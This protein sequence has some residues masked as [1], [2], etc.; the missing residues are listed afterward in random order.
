[1]EKAPQ[2]AVLIAGG[3]VVP[4]RGW[5]MAMHRHGFHEMIAV[6]EGEMTVTFG[7]ERI[8][9]GPGDVLIYHAERGHAEAS[10][11]VRAVRTRFLAFQ[12]RADDL[13]A[14][15]VDTEGR[16]RDLVSWIVTDLGHGA[17]RTEL[18]PLL[19]A[20]LAELRRL[21]RSPSDP[22]VADLRRH[23]RK[24]LADP[25]TLDDL[26]ARGGMSKF[27]FIRSYRRATGRTPMQ[28]LRRIRLNQARTLILAT[29]LPL[30]AIAAEVGLGDAF[31]MARLFRRHFQ[32]A[33][34]HLR[35]GGAGRPGVG[36]RG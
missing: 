23:M 32:T 15:T 11:P 21:N 12:G 34:S 28:D 25:L 13:P 27:A 35:A 16:V 19:H 5:G 1:M 31:Q 14:R 4:R 10:H 29:G 18:A 8:E 20:A 22:W 24:H 26:A 36:G 2:Q 33:P 17:S 30:K 7:D 3:E 9:A 6:L